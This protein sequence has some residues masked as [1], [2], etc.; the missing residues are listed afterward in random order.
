MEFGVIAPQRT[1]NLRHMVSEQ[2]SSCHFRF[3]NVL[4]TCRNTLIVLKITLLNMTGFVPHG[5]NRSPQPA[6]DGMKEVGPTT[7]CA[8]VAS[9]GNAHD[10]KNERQLTAWLGLTP[11]QYSSDGKSKLDRMTKAGDSY[12]RTLLV[13]GLVRF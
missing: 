3:N 5:K 10:F 13:Q 1:N 8:L 7:A 6:I 9:I 4:M 11:S 2:K 12:L